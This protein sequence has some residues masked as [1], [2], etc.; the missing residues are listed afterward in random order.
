MKKYIIIAAVSTFLFVGCSKVNTNPDG[1]STATP[2]SEGSASS[3]SGTSTGSGKTGG[4]E[5][6]PN[7]ILP[8]YD[9]GDKS[10]CYTITN[11]EEARGFAEYVFT[12]IDC[13]GKIHTTALEA[14]QSYSFCSQTGDV[15]A[16]FAYFVIVGGGNC[17]PK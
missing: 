9:G 11:T 15:K 3:G 4:I 1:Q 16:N 5:A 7:P 10:T 2:S 6:K 8:I 12:Y 14:G 17:G 13:G